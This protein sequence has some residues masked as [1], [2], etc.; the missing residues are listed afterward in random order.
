MTK[1]KISFQTKLILISSAV[2][3]GFNISLAAFGH[4]PGKVIQS[5]RIPE[6]KLGNY[7]WSDSSLHKPNTSYQLKTV[8]IDAGHGGH[9]PGCHGASA[10][11]KHVTL[12]I[13]KKLAEQL[14]QRFP[15]LKVVLTRDKDVF[16]PLYERADI[17]NKHNADLFISIH[18]NAMPGN[19]SGTYGTE[20]YVMGLHTAQYNLEVAKRENAAILLEDNYQKNY[21][22]NPNSPE[23]H[24]MIS[25]FQNAY[26][27][28]SLQF[29]ELVENKLNQQ[30]KRKSRGVKQAGFVV[31]KATAMP[32]VLVEVGFLTNPAE[33]QFLNG[34][35]GQ[36]Q[37]AGAMLEAFTLYKNH[38]ES[39]DFNNDSQ[40]DNAG[41]KEAVANTNNTANPVAYSYGSSKQ[42][43]NNTAASQR[44]TNT[45][46]LAKPK[47]IPAPE[48]ANDP[49]G[50]SHNAGPNHT[51][52]SNT[53]SR[54][55]PVPP[56]PNLNRNPAPNNPMVNNSSAEV[57]FKIQLAATPAAPNQTESKW[58]TF[59]F[60]LEVAQE[61]NL[62]KVRTQAYADY[63][64]ANQVRSRCKELGFNDA[65]IVAFKDGK[66]I[67]LP[68]AK[69]VLGIP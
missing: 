63:Q 6:D 48:R 52:Y 36:D 12:A 33:E 56:G 16:I 46:E 18:C 64:Q 69:K 49:G 54:Y 19:N 3:L 5:H 40:Y 44:E 35:F 67:S 28:Q 27:K 22:Y 66:R 31:L 23:G 15:G 43:Q 62:Y 50:N 60:P 47:E 14:Q 20:T 11:E 61:D 68:E 57:N 7:S 42:N 59:P 51:S 65:F 58:K 1:T 53:A 26:L 25:M 21:D 45:A 32:S 13:A 37:V 17:A 38:A 30:A 8:V 10:H 2:I 29:A 55:G 4:R 34:Q 9:D 39:P 41:Q 24:I